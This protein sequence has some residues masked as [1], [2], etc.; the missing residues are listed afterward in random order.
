M[1]EI[2]DKLIEKIKKNEKDSILLDSPDSLSFEIKKEN[3]SDIKKTIIDKKTAFVDG[4]NLEIF[5]SPSLSLFFNRVYYTIYRENKRISNRLF[6]FF[7][8]ISAENSVNKIVFK[9]DLHFTKNKLPI[10]EFYFDSFDPSLV[11][12]EKRAEI[13]SVGDT[14][15]RLAELSAAKDIDADFVVLDGTL[16]AIYPY[17]KEIIESIKS[18]L[19]GLSKTTSLLTKNG[20][21]AVALLK[22]FTERDTWKYHLGKGNEKNH[23]VNIYFLK[24]N[25]KSE[26]ILRFETTKKDVADEVISILVE[27]SKDPVFLGYPYGLIEVDKFARVSKKEKETLQLQ[28]MVL[29]GK[30][31]EKIKP[32]LNSLNAHDILDKI[33]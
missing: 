26:Y 24:L 28:L 15:R 5:R 11:K 1:K 7:T 20:G 19:F 16:E 31:G 4:G 25:Y 29:F 8:L 30:H 32:Y 22:G 2:V 23:D 14:V 33:S 18:P 9:A 12:G 27:N 17:E 13:S 21:T 6:E 10:E 3:F